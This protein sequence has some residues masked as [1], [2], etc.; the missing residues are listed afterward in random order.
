MFIFRHSFYV[1]PDMPVHCSI[2]EYKPSNIDHME[3][4]LEVTDWMTLVSEGVNGR[5]KDDSIPAGIILG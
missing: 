4:N 2:M 3:W 5:T 1:T